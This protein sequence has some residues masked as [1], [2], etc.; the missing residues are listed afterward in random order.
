MVSIDKVTLNNTDISI[1]TLNSSHG[2]RSRHFLSEL[3]GLKERHLEAI[4]RRRREETG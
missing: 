3:K 2:R 1:S 4:S